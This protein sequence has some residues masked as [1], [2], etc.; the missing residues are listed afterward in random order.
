MELSNQVAILKISY[1]D[2]SREAHVEFRTGVYINIETRD[3]IMSWREHDKNRMTN[4]TIVRLVK[5]LLRKNR[6]PFQSLKIRILWA[7]VERAEE[8][9]YFFKHLL[10]ELL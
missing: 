10:F 8:N 3:F 5:Y 1:D 9:E 2:R 7:E 6:N 4:G